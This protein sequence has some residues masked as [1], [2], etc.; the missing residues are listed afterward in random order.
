MSMIKPDRVL[1]A[2][3]ALLAAAFFSGCAA[4][5]PQELLD[6]RTAYGEAGQSRAPQYAPAQLQTARDALGRAEETFDDLGDSE[7][8][9]DLSYVAQRR[10]QIAMVQ[11]NI[12]ESEKQ[13]EIAEKELL[14]TATS[15]A[16][17]KSDQLRDMSG[18]LDKERVE[19]AA[20]AARAREA[21]T[22][23]KEAMDR[24]TAIASIKEEPR[25]LVITL[26]G[27]VLFE[28][29]KATLLASAKERLNQVADAL[30]QN[31]D[32]N[33]VV[34][35]HT[36]SQGDDAS[37]Q[38]LSED[39]AKSVREY[40]VSRGIA[41]DRVRSVGQGEKTPVADNNNSEGRANNRR[42][43]IIV[44]RNSSSK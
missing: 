2:T 15:T 42:V 23:L 31:R 27:G 41:N 26:P 1:F 6:A 22:K 29:G 17:S 20:V 13:K 10:A 34:E 28:S 24:L 11:G 38:K 16:E 30:L 14:N 5:A 18:Q 44:E 3:P 37:N 39:R 33:I 36:D 43:E 12:K 21:E 32:A 9:R 7:K 8:T 35:G 19:K 40:L 4:T 25:G